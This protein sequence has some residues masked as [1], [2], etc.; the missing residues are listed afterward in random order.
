M[1]EHKL[2]IILK[3]DE[4]P[5]EGTKLYLEPPAEDDKDALRD[6]GLTIAMEVAAE[7]LT[8]KNEVDPVKIVDRVMKGE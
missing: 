2:P 4:L 6:F 8:G 3:C 5:P 1:G 7:I